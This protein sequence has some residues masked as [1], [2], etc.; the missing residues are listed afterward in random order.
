MSSHSVVFNKMARDVSRLNG[1]D[2][3][4]YPHLTEGIGHKATEIL[5]GAA[6]GIALTWLLYFLLV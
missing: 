5:A 1:K 3:N 4:E 2:E 6:F